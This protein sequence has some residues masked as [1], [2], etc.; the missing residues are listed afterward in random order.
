MSA[1]ESHA[2][3]YI[4][5]QQAQASALPAAGVAVLDHSRSEALQLLG[6]RGLPTQRDEDWKYT[7]IK[8][9][10]RSRFSP[11]IP[12]NDCPEDFV[13]AAAIKDL[14][15]WQL[16]F[17]DGF[18]LPHRSKT[19]G[20]PEGVRV[21]SLADALTK[22]PESIADRLGSVMGEIP[23]GFAAMNSAF[24]GD[25]ALVEIAPGVQLEKPVELLFVSGC[26]GEGLLSLPRNLVTLGVGSRASV[27]ERHLSCGEERSLSNALTEI[28]LEED[29]SLDYCCIQDQAERTFHVGGL[30]AR[31]AGSAKLKATTATVGRAWVRNDARVNLDA[32]GAFASLD[33][34][35]LAFGRC[36][37]D[38]HTHISHN[39]PECTSR[40]C[41]KGVLGDRGHAVFHGRIVVQPGAQ[42]TDS[43]QSNQN[44]LLSADAEIDTKP[45]LE[46]YAD[47]VKC[48]HGATVGQLDEAA[49]FY[50]VSR[51]VDPAAARRMLTQA[52]AAE[53]LETIKPPALQTYLAARVS[54]QLSPAVPTDTVR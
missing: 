42:K 29:A 31:V 32:K 54:G 27:I 36:H 43:A 4:E 14:D 46:I 22:K 53:V 25:G 15:A 35:Y 26:S 39:A 20:L 49:L 6:E 47:D 30:F 10:T 18:Y 12:G 13:A 19:N 7:S 48:A 51:G 37:V 11:A 5:A 52:F 34:A 9:I 2:A 16:V 38:N 28:I 40:E 50:I 17:A 45:Q 33:G 1:A 8:P 44:L 41:Y 21:A 23:H 24:V 3:P